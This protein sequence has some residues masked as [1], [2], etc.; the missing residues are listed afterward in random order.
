MGE[1]FDAPAATAG[2]A[3]NAN[4]VAHNLKNSNPGASTELINSVTHAMVRSGMAVADA[5]AGLARAQNSSPAPGPL[6]RPFPEIQPA[7]EAEHISGEGLGEL[8]PTAADGMAL[9]RE[10]AVEV[11]LEDWAGEL[12][13][14]TRLCNHLGVSR[15]T[16]NAWRTAHDIIALPKGKRNHVYPLLQFKNSRPISGISELLDLTSGN[17]LVAWR[18]L[19]TPNVDFDYREPIKLLKEGEKTPVLE[20]AHRSFD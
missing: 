17:A 9:L 1:Q 10:I 15:S 18:W 2:F 7:T 3:I 19:M 12:A 8:L 13:T 20:A 11:P 4:M 6:R 16:I 14:P 5:V